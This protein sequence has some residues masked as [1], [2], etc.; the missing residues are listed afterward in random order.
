M[1][2]D[3]VNTPPAADLLRVNVARSSIPVL[4]VTFPPLIVTVP[5]SVQVLGLVMIR[6]E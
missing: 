5:P 4:C 2:D 1:P 6:F 3:A